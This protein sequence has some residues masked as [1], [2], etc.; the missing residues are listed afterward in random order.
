MIVRLLLVLMSALATAVVSAQP[1]P[2]KAVRIVV[3]LSPGTASDVL[4][5]AYADRLSALW[6]QSVVVEN[7]AG[8]N[9]LIGAQ[10]VGEARPDGY[11]L[12]VGGPNHL[13]NAYL[14]KSLPYDPIKSFSPI[15]QMAV[16]P[17]VLAVHPSVPAT[18]VSA[19]VAYAK[20]HGGELSYGSPGSGAPAHLAMELLKSTTGAKLEHTPY[21]AASQAQS[22][23]IAGH[24]HA[25]FLVPSVAVPQAKSGRMRLLGVSRSPIFIPP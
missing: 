11:T 18:T 16:I 4:A 7:I 6:S 22:D 25:M 5:R 24:I 9:G 10:L 19:L 23:L 15:A 8:A 1:F 3:P 14:Y 2:T 12:F 21:K 17:L 20:A 13:I